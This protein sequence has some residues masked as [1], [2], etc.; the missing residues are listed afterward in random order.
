M[1]A[2]M[3]TKVTELLISDLYRDIYRFFLNKKNI[4]LFMNCVQSKIH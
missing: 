2:K 3:Q 1:S 4:M